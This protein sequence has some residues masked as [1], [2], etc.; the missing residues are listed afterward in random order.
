M[1]AERYSIGVDLG[2]T[3]LRAAAINENGSVLSRIS[4]RTNLHEGRE[5][6]VEDIVEAIRAAIAEQGEAGLTGVGVAV[7]G[8][9]EM[10]KGLVVGSSNL[11]QFDGFPVRDEISRSLGTAVF[12]E[13][14]ANAAA[15]GE[16]WI[17]AGKDVHSLVLLTMGTGIG[18]G[19]IAG[20][21]ILHGM[22]G[23]A[24]EI[25]H[26]TVYPDGNPCGC[27]NNGCLDKHASATA[28]ACM[29]QMLKLGD[30][31][32]AAEVFEIAQGGG[33]HAAKAKR[34]FE[35]VGAALGIA[36][37]NLVNIFN[38][39]LYLLSGGPLPAWDL[40]APVMMREI[41]RRSFTFSNTRTRIEK[42]QLGA[43]AGLF[44]AAYLP[45]ETGRGP[46]SDNRVEA[47]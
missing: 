39:P 19:I 12:L 29:A 30:D 10:E 35:S 20:G 7:P 32:S 23:M 11:P 9:I 47:S 38:F 41:E 4:G 15:M 33:E 14:D 8:F 22:T 45:L 16:K 36:I 3:N 26:T 37:A 24:G 40:F 1:A 18:G 42:A 17:G 2:G 27:G 43:D 6:V 21:R 31:L 46:V 25:G 28:I 13:N 5:A 44:G 34:V